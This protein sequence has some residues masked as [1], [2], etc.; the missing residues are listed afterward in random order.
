MKS[1]SSR[2]QF[3]HQ[4]GRTA[5]LVST[6]SLLG[7]ARAAK[8]K[9]APIKVGQIGVGH[10]HADGK[11]KALRNSP[12]WDV[13]GVVEPDP[14]LRSKA[15][16]VTTYEGLKWMTAEELLNVPGLEAVAVETKVNQLLDAAE[17]CIAAGKHIHL[18]KPPG[19][20][21]P[22]FRQ[23]WSEADRQRLTIQMGYMYRYNPG[24]VLLHE[25]LRKGW[26]G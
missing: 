7:K 12:D 21:L 20:N 22:S 18:D 16:Q 14:E 25:F 17:M 19:S 11:M 4:S 5:A 2:R 26:L 9:K 15:E 8:S 23:L 10:A 3:L 13:V 24:I 6:L 1:K